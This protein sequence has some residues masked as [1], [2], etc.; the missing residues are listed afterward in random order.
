MLQEYYEQ[1]LALKKMILSCF[2]QVGGSK[3]SGLSKHPTQ[4]MQAV[5]F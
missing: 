2:V 1:H 5:N 3:S 4:Q